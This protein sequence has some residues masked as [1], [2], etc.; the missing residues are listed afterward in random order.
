MRGRVLLV[1]G[2]C[3]MIAGA[4]ITGSL[5]RSSL[6]VV[7]VPV[8]ARDLPAFTEVESSDLR[9]EDRPAAGLHPETVLEPRGIV[10]RYTL[11]DMF[12]GEPLLIGRL[13]RGEGDRISLRLPG[14]RRAFAVPAGSQG[15]WGQIVLPGDSV[16]VIWTSPETRDLEAFATTILTNIPVVDVI[17]EPGGLRG[18]DVLAVIVEVEGTGAARLALALASGRVSIAV[19]GPHASQ[20]IHLGPVTGRDLLTPEW[21]V[22]PLPD[23]EGW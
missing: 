12:G 1:V 9:L 6:K 5:V 14:D 2:I 17:R 22:D 3:L 19:R 4:S 20:S 21:D 16:D 11:V 10:G 15:L 18:A 23:E 13:S 8:L 7:S